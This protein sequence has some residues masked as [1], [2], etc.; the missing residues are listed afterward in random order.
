[1]NN[2]LISHHL[3]K[4]CKCN[5]CDNMFETR[6]DMHNHIKS[7]HG[8]RTKIEYLSKNYN[9]LLLSLNNQNIKLHESI[10]NLKQKEAQSRGGCLYKGY[11]YQ[12][13]KI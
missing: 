1:M 11:V 10:Y 9:D 13:F 12:S 3:A 5:V 2:H 6:D 8:Y 4:K 7:K